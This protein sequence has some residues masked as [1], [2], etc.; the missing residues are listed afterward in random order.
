MKALVL[1]FDG[2]L[3]QSARETFVVGLATYLALEPRSRLARAERTA[4]YDEFVGAMPLGNRAEDFGVVLAALDRRAALP[5]QDAYDAFHRSVGAAWL[6]AFH[7]R[8]YE[9]RAALA[10][11]DPS[12]W[13]AMN[14]P[15]A[16]F[17]ALLRRRAGAVPYAI[18]TAKDRPSVDRLLSAWGAADLFE[19]ALV[20]DKEVAVSKRAHLEALARHLDLPYAELTFV[21][22]KVNHLDDVAGLGVRCALAAWGY[23]GPREHALAR[24][25]GYRV[26]TLEDADTQL[27][28]G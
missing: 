1:D 26:C 15:Y 23:N 22:D 18:A 2:V 3:C 6:R 20:L 14:P 19:P 16:P 11:R 24:A 7:A 25:R 9:E 13:L 17:L 12:G 10:A 4:L 28:A 5:D 21:D 8:F 27:F